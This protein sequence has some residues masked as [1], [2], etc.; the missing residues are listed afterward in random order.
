M[1]A[2]A[3]VY[4]D[5]SWIYCHSCNRSK[6]SVCSV[7][8]SKC[9]IFARC[10]AAAAEKCPD[11]ERCAVH[12]PIRK[13]EY[14]KSDWPDEYH[15]GQFP[16]LEVSY[17]KSNRKI[18]RCCVEYVLSRALTVPQDARRRISKQRKTQKRVLLY[19][20]S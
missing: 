10:G 11:C 9:Y 2:L 17:D 6:V 5:E 20:S 3:M 4:G 12:W 14:S 8:K 19:V 1:S 18:D 13:S 16:G 15:Q 7:N